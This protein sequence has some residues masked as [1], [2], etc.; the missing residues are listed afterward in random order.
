[1]LTTK[2]LLG[3]TPK[4]ALAA[5]LNDLNPGMRVDGNDLIVSDPVVQSGTVTNVNLTMR[6]S[7]AWNDFVP[8]TG[9]VPFQ[10][11]RLDI[12]NFA[13]LTFIDFNP[14]LPTTTQVLLDELNL[15]FGIVFDPNDFFI[16]NIDHNN[17]GTYT[18]RAQPNSLRWIGEYTLNLTAA[19]QITV[20]LDGPLNPTLGVP[21]SVELTAANG[22]APYVW[23]NNGLPNGYTVVSNSPTTAILSGS[24]NAQGTSQVTVIAQDAQQNQG[25]L[26]FPFT[27]NAASFSNPPVSFAESFPAGIVGVPYNASVPIAGGDGTY[28]TPR[29]TTGTLDPGLRLTISGK[30]L[31]LS[32]T[33]TAVSNTY[34]TYQVTSGDFQVGTLN[35]QLVIIAPI[36]VN[37]AFMQGEPDTIYTDAIPIT[38]G[39]GDYFDLVINQLPPGITDM[40]IYEK[41]LLM[42]G[43][44]G[45]VPPGRYPLSVTFSS[46]Y[47][48]LF[49]YTQSFIIR[50]AIRQGPNMTLQAMKFGQPSQQSL[51][52]LI[53]L[54]N[55]DFLFTVADLN[56]SSPIVGNNG[57]TDTNVTVTP[58]T[59]INA[60]GSVVLEYQRLDIGRYFLGAQVELNFATAVTPANILAQLLT[61]Y[62]IYSSTDP[63]NAF[64]VVVN[65]NNP[66]QATITPAATNLVWVG[67]LSVA[68][69]AR[70]TMTVLI[71][72][73]NFPGFG[74]P[75]GS[76]NQPNAEAYFG[77]INGQQYLNDIVATPQGATFNT[78]LSAWQLGTEL[79]NQT[80]VA[81]ATPGPNNIYGATVLHN[82]P[83]TGSFALTEASGAYAG[84]V[85]VIQLSA[86]CTNYVG[87][88]VIAYIPATGANPVPSPTPAPVPV[89][90]PTPT[91]PTPAPTP[92]PAPVPTPVPPTPTPTPTP[93]PVP[94]PTPAPVPPTPTPTPVPA[95]VPPTPT[96]TPTPAPVP[97]PVPAPTP[98]PTPVPVPAPVPT[99]APTPTAEANSQFAAHPRLML[100]TPTLSRMQTSY[101]NNDASW[102]GIKAYCDSFLSGNVLYPDGNQYPDL[103]DIGAGYQGEEYVQFVLACALVY[104]TMRITNPAAALPYGQKGVTILMAMSQLSPS[105]HYW[106]PSTDDG[107]GIRNYGVGYGL[108]YDWLFDLLTPAQMTQV[109]TCAATWITY[110]EEGTNAGGTFEYEHPLTNYFAG[111]FHAK[112]V[113]SLAMYDEASSAVSSW[114]DLL[115]NEFA[116]KILPYY[117]ANMKG[118]G[119]P[120]GWG[121]YGPVAVFH[122]TMPV[123]AIDTA[124]KGATNLINEGF[125]FPLDNSDYLM[126]FTWPSLYYVD[127]RDTNHSTGDPTRI[128]CTTNPLGFQAAGLALDRYGDP[129]RAA[130]FRSYQNAVNAA[131]G[132][133]TLLSTYWQQFLTAPS[134][135]T[136]QDYKTALPLAYMTTGM[137]EVAARSDWT[138]NASWMSYRAG[139]YTDNPDQGEQGWDEGSLSLTKGAN[140]LLV[141]TEGWIIRE[142]GGNADENSLYADL[143]GNFNGTA[144]LGNRQC[145]NIFYVRNMTNSTTVA[146][147]Y[148]QVGVNRAGGALT[149][150]TLY[151]N[152][153]SFM[154]LRSTHLED[155]YRTFAEGTAVVKSNRDVLYLRPNRFITFDQ[156][157]KGNSAWDDFLAWH[158]PA[159]PAPVSGLP[160]GQT[161]YGITYNSVYTGQVTN[162]LPANNVPTVVPLYPSSSPVKVW[163]VQVRPPAGTATTN[164]SKMWLTVHDM[165]ATPAVITDLQGVGCGAI[166]MS[167][168]DGNQVA[169]FA[170][171]QTFSYNQPQAAQ[172]HLVVGLTPGSKY[173]VSSNG[174]TVTVAPGSTYTAS[175]GG[176]ISY[177][178]ATV[179]FGLAGTLPDATQNQPYSKTLALTGSFVAPVTFTGMPSWLTATL[180]GNIVTFAGTAPA[181]TSSASIT[182]SATDSSSTP[183]VATHTQTFNVDQATVM[184]LSGTLAAN[185]LSPNT[186]FSGTLN[187]TGTY[188]EPLTFGVQSGTLPSWL[189]ASYAAGTGVVTYAGTT[190]AGGMASVNFTP[191]VTDS[192]PTP[193]VAVGTQ[194]TV[195]VNTPPGSYWDP[196]N[197]TSCLNVSN[198]LATNSVLGYTA[199]Q[200]TAGLSMLT[201]TFTGLV[202]VEAIIT[203]AS[204]S[205]NQGAGIG[206]STAKTDV[207]N[208][209]EVAG[210]AHAGAAIYAPDGDVEQSYP[211]PGQTLTTI[212]AGKYRFGVLIDP[213]NNKWWATCNGTTWLK[214]SDGTVGAPAT[215]LHSLAA[216]TVAGG[217]YYIQGTSTFAGNTVEVVTDPK[218][219]QWTS[220]IPAGLSPQIG[221]PGP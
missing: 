76:A 144:F 98:T 106:P 196:A 69:D 183:K 206:W 54:Y 12:A 91:P 132:S 48:Q 103:P 17:G 157:T 122:M 174:S 16:E 137:F 65:P 204:G 176:T 27:V 82:G 170:A 34:Q 165:A 121:N 20:T 53:N 104:Q 216:P 140:P 171:G 179:A 86:A 4:N 129:T 205:P 60:G 2:Q 187:V 66:N 46:G 186:T 58:T 70:P 167:G 8:Y 191:K 88:L 90:T 5:M 1:M 37:D 13:A 77:V 55:P 150:I 178:L 110:W 143:T 49:T 219:M 139:P 73:A 113:M 127:N 83:A 52:D 84:N 43:E 100:D 120:E 135:T 93:A 95:P 130:V 190:P 64:S 197:T 114:N 151:E 195:E 115:P 28:N 15:L 214:G 107:Y 155:Q 3:M 24:G 185:N 199:G 11:N 168:I 118:G 203:I 189:V 175:V 96:P 163:Q 138:T 131:L 102:Q 9:S 133:P 116:N 201:Q 193:Q 80:W 134:H 173:D 108:A 85:L 180:A 33:P 6:R 184:G 94:T 92:V 21:F 125:T 166:A 181:S 35:Q 19:A 45:E 211:Q 145:Y 153:T 59:A 207:V 182:I 220:I 78:P 149:G 218:N 136:T 156:T 161:G 101:V 75:A 154:Y 123:W 209:H 32:G 51:V 152:E 212:S 47:N 62:Q 169:V 63:A 57:P 208:N 215:G 22:I 164:V 200:T 10:Y 105:A 162:V 111:Y 97:T 31:V 221:I 117:T 18:L 109:S 99:P 210:S 128:P 177:N 126:H 217:P 213:V 160:A 40:I 172:I 26:S 41:M 39:T 67:S 188:R 158:Y 23:L 29:V 79:F 36:A 142:P 148:G 119:W 25:S 44:I 159:N 81:N 7:Y 68:I 14:A 30:S 89:P 61:Q 42:S 74:T 146:E 56:F 71:P 202:Y 124:T 141:N 192:S 50:Y 194:Q 198:G 72:N 38:G 112:T 147:R 87:N